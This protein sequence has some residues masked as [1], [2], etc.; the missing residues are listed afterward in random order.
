MIW[1][2]IFGVI[3]GDTRSSDYSSYAFSRFMCATLGHLRQQTR[4]VGA[5]LL[6]NYS[7]YVMEGSK[8]SHALCFKY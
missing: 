3:K 8:Q 7:D 4:N 6:P 5:Y 1:G 2:S